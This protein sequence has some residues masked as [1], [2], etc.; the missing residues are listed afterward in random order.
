MAVISTWASAAA[1]PKPNAN[2]G[3]RIRA[4]HAL[5]NA[6]LVGLWR[7]VAADRNRHKA[8]ARR[9]W[10]EKAD[11]CARRRRPAPRQ[12]NANPTSAR[13]VGSGTPFDNSPNTLSVDWSKPLTDRIPMA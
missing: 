9:A 6:A 5:A 13:V 8:R 3:G 7:L 11:Q 12:A 4:F 2:G 10:F 1:V